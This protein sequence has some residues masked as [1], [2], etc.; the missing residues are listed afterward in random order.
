MDTKVGK[1]VDK[2]FD[3][4]C[5]VVSRLLV[6][7]RLRRSCVWGGDAHERKREAPWGLVRMKQRVYIL[8]L[9]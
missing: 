9:V 8:H 4:D 1:V 5:V 3:D 6:S 7:K 2:D